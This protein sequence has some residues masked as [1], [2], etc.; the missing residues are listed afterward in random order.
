M[1]KLALISAL[2]LA[3]VIPSQSGEAYRLWKKTQ[4][5][6]KI[7]ET[8][9]IVIPPPSDPIPPIPV[10]PPLIAANVETIDFKV[11]VYVYTF[12]KDGNTFMIAWS[13]Q[14]ISMIQVK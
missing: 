10:P 2:V 11:G 14:H 7:L 8:P 6:A 3:T 5:D 4:E 13:N 12:K 1:K 9:D